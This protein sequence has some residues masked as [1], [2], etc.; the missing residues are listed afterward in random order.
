[1]ENAGGNR[2]RY[3]FYK[4]IWLTLTN[5]RIF[6]YLPSQ[7]VRHALHQRY[8]TGQAYMVNW[9]YVASVAFILTHVMLQL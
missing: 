8:N 4:G 7:T 3:D 2:F 5:N 6:S 1:M 9:L